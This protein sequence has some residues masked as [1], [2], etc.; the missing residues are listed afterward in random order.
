[1]RAAALSSQYRRGGILHLYFF[2][3][4]CAFFLISERT[5]KLMHS[6]TSFFRPVP[7]AM[8][9]WYAHPATYSAASNGSLGF[10]LDAHMPVFTTH[11]LLMLN[12][13]KNVLKFYID[14]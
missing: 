6:K 4:N 3:L 1:V 12:R 10:L 5:T 7:L 13:S 9:V 8:Y 2:H 14:L 11:K